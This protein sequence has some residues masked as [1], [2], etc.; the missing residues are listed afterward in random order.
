MGEREA[1]VEETRQ[2]MLAA[3]RLMI[4]ETGFH[5]A[6]L[7]DIARQADVT[8]ATL[9]NHFGSKLGLL[10][11]VTTDALQ[12]AGLNQLP[13]LLQLPD[14]RE[15]WEE[16][17]RAA[18]RMWAAEHE[19]FRKVIGLAGVDPEALQIV[20]K[21][22]AERRSAMEFL[23]S[24]LAD[25]GCLRQSHTRS[26]AQAVLTLLTSFATFDSLYTVS[27]IAPDAIADLLID[28]SRTVIE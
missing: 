14:A 28:L 7:R 1:G 27:G 25:Q 2:R 13:P 21:R 15:A 9:Y 3:A 26:Q 23:T 8:R 10:D 11:A 16:S 17:T 24:R 18:M 12:R 19:L 5:R 6:S 20:E 22:D 4:V